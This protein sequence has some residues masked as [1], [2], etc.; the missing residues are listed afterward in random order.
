MGAGCGR[1]HH[2][3][4]GSGTPPG[5]GSPSPAANDLVLRMETAGGFV[6]PSYRYGAVPEFSLFG[7]G[8]V[9]EP[10][11]HTEIF[12]PPALVEPVTMQVDEVG[13]QAIL[14]A[15]REAGLFGPD[16][17]YTILTVADAGTTTFT[18]VSDGQR[19]IISVYGLGI[20]NTSPQM[21]DDERVVREK[22][23]A[24][25]QKLMDL[26]SWLPNGSVS[27]SGEYQPTG[28]EVY[29]QD[30]APSQQSPN[31]PVVEWPLATPLSNFGDPLQDDNGWRCGT[32]AGDDFTTLKA[33]VDRA[34]SISP[35]TS[36]GSG[37][38]LTFR[39][40]LPDETQCPNALG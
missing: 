16:A 33:A 10:G 25:Q 14:D 19:H 11:L 40:L 20:D 26:Q 38:S 12:P 30:G 31:E 13:I 36:E 37:F 2:T 3:G 23:A 27:D 5:S 32:V 28:V 8:Q 18:L 17:H 24:F 39:P 21:T 34:T 22:L 1:L 29:V 6:I 4:S 9:V 7:D 35:W 15:A